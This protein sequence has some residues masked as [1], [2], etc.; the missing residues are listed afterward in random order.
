VQVIRGGLRRQ[1]LIAASRIVG[2][3]PGR[4]RELVVWQRTVVMAMS[5]STL[6]G[7]VSVG[8]IVCRS[9]TGIDIHSP[10]PESMPTEA[11][12][13]TSSLQQHRSI[14]PTMRQLD[15]FHCNHGMVGWK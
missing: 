4:R 9:Q 14:G 12:S 13:S 1:L 8:A 3:G 2:T 6:V 11:S 15:V 10:V 7:R 5:F